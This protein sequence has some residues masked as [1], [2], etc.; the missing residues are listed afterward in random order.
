MQER[1]GRGAAARPVPKSALV[2]A[3]QRERILERAQAG[4]TY[5]QIS[6]VESLSRSRVRQ[7]VLKAVEATPP[8][9]RD[10][11]R[12][13]Q[14]LRLQAPLRLL[15]QNIASGD[16]RSVMP[17]IKLLGC[18]DGYQNQA[19]ATAEDEVE[20]HRRLMAKMN[21]LALRAKQEATRVKG[22][23]EVAY[24]R[25]RAAMQAADEKI[26][27]MENSAENSPSDTEIIEEKEL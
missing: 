2:R 27:Q 26:R 11:H 7:I 12:R 22:A 18:M 3:E 14:L 21:F 4:Q 24:N 20:G 15:S 10:W 5:A 23:E 6:R 17:L 8:E 13:M 19:T 25:K 1:A 16:A 9:A